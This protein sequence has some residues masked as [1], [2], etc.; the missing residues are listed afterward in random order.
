[1]EAE[2]AGEDIGCARGDD[3][4]GDPC[5]RED[6]GGGSEGAVPAEEDDRLGAPVDEVLR[7]P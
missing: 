6:R 1:M 3:E 5:G 2:P 4:D 7:L